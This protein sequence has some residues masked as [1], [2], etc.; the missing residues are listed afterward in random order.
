MCIAEKIK[1]AIQTG[2]YVSGTKLPPERVLAEKLGVSRNTVRLAIEEL[3]AETVLE[4][5]ARHGTYVA[6]GAWTSIGKRKSVDWPKYFKNRFEGL[7]FDDTP[8][9]S[10]RYPEKDISFIKQFFQNVGIPEKEQHKL[11]SADAKQSHGSVSLRHAVAEHLKR[12]GITAE[13]SNVLITSST[14]QATHLLTTAFLGTGSN[15]YYE[16]GSYITLRGILKECGAN[17]I[18]LPMDDEGLVIDKQGKQ[19]LSRKRAVLHIQPSNN[20]PTGITTSLK[21]REEIVKAFSAKGVPVIEMDSMIDIYAENKHPVPIKVLDCNNA[22]IFVGNMARVTSEDVSLSWVV[23][24]E[25]IINML[26][27][28]KNH[29]DKHANTMAQLITELSFTSGF[30]YEYMERFRKF[31]IERRDAYNEI[32]YKYLSNVAVWEPTRSSYYFWPEFNEDINIKMLHRNVKGMTFNPGYFYDPDD[33]RHISICTLA[34]PPEKFDW[35]L[36]LLKKDMERKK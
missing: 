15:F 31:L 29:K 8:D 12:Y 20:H 23:A 25:Y 6:E 30:Y 5:K 26:A 13:A 27:A 32:M 4:A 22:V 36:S 21:R 3:I 34:M 7:V 19:A 16:K 28:L 9:I 10:A 33:S 17:T 35:A 11:Y 18:R 1:K 24:D 14:T 2:E